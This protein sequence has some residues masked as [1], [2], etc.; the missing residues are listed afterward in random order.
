M[1]QVFCSAWKHAPIMMKRILVSIIT[2]LFFGVITA[3]TTKVLF[4]GNSFTHNNDLPGM[5][6]DFALAAGENTIVDSSTHGGYSW[7]Q[8]CAYA[9][10]LSKINLQDWDYVALQQ[11]GELTA[12]S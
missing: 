3:Q 11:K 12:L 6:H 2:V 9:P 7:Q 8:H 5:F 1:A 4:I 10:T